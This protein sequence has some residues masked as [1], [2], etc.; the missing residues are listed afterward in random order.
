ML[1]APLDD[2][3]RSMVS[4]QWKNPDFLFKNP[5]FLM[6]NPDFLL[7][8]VDFITKQVLFPTFPTSKWDVKFKMHAPKNTTIEVSCKKGAV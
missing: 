8:N 6:K 7:K 3:A 5:D 2:D 1:M 4:F